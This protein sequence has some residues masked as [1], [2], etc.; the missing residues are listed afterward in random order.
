MQLAAAPR[1]AGL[2]A[3]QLGLAQQK[4]LGFD[5]RSPEIRAEW[6]LE[7]TL[8]GINL[9]DAEKTLRDVL[10]YR[11][12][13]D[14]RRGWRYTNPNLE[15]LGLLSVDYRG[16]DELVNDAKLYKPPCP[17]KEWLM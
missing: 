12:W 4:A 10:A 1:P 14:Q 2:R 9:E 5:A 11:V 3:E 7:P 17:N 15:E 16:I 6:L 13:F 8:R